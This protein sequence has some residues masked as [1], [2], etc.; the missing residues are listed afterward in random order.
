[1]PFAITVAGQVFYIITSPEDTNLFYRNTKTLTFDE[2]IE[3]S[4]TDLGVTPDGVR[5][6]F[7]KESGARSLAS[8][9]QELYRIQFLTGE[10]ADEFWATIHGSIDRSLQCD[11]LPKDAVLNSKGRAHTLSLWRWTR[12]TLI[13]AI[14]RG[15]YGDIIFEL[16]PDL[17]NIFAAFDDNSWKMMHKYPKSAARE[18]YDSLDKL[19]V[20]FQKYL[21]LPDEKRKGRAWV[22]QILEAKFKEFNLEG[23]DLA[24]CL[25]MP[26]WV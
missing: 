2:F 18:V 8:W 23:R 17:V 1:M 15:L 25:I 14:S 20:M 7:P 19:N 24:F 26:F 21:Q 5:K 22:L 4:M 3:D 12:N 6:A 9:A 10:R 11:T 13:E 16:E